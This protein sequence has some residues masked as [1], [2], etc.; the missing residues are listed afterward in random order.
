MRIDITSLQN[1]VKIHKKEI[2]KCAEFVL[3]AMGEDAAELS[4]LFVDEAYIK[5]LNSRYR[6][7]DSATDVL[8]FSMR[9][10]EGCSKDSPILG[11]V[12]ISVDTAEREANQRKITTERELCLYLVHGILHLLGYDDK[13][14]REKKRMMAKEKELLDMYLET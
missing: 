9:E 6:K 5:I 14:A 4:L 10:G 2:K 13:K 8:A 11:D 1:K 7:V 12:V 3:K